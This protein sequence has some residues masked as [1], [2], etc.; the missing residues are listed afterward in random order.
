VTFP[1]PT[2]VESSLEESEAKAIDEPNSIDDIM[3][4]TD[5]TWLLVFLVMTTTPQML[6]SYA[7]LTSPDKLLRKSPLLTKPS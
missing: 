7:T 3:Q 1:R 6:E 5:R 4:I 2:V